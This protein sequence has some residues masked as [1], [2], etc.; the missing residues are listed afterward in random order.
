MNGVCWNYVKISNDVDIFVHKDFCEDQND[1]LRF[2]KKIKAVQV[3]HKVSIMSWSNKL[4]IK[5]H[6]NL[7]PKQL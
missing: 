3:E 6:T 7:Y 5:P 2:D 1:P 4:K